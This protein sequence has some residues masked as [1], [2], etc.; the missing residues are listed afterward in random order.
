M[1][2]FAGRHRH[3]PP[4]AGNPFALLPLERFKVEDPK[5]IF[6]FDAR[7]ELAFLQ[8]CDSWAFAVHFTLAKTGLRVGEL[9]HL[10]IEDVDLPGGW[11]YVR[12]KSELGWRIK[13]GVERVVPLL[14]E[15]LLVM[16]RVVGK[17][18]MGVLFLRPRCQ[19]N[20]PPLLG[21]RAALV[22]ELRERHIANGG[23]L[24]RAEAA[25][26]AESVWRDA[27][28]IDPNAIRMSFLRIAA[29]IGHPEATCPKSWR[30]TFATL[31][32]D[33]N[34]DPLI[35]QRVLGHTP[36]QRSGLGMTAVYTH[37]RP[38]TARQQLQDALR[39]WPESLRLVEGGVR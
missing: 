2:A 6:V 3:L 33:A 28:A 32:Q 27:G 15:L 34:V 7:T 18:S 5:P 39:R 8:A 1:Y 16:H 17:R 21:N 13:T 26:L 19:T 22:Q 35:R 10:L 20:P 4:Y 31:L 23:T 14:P 37:T 30:H 24:S 36:T 29:S 11:L 25:K 12:N 38:E 9:T